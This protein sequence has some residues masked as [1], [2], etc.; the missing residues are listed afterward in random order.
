MVSSLRSGHRL[1][2]T[3]SSLRKYY[4]QFALLGLRC[5]ILLISAL[6]PSNL[7]LRTEIVTKLVTSDVK[8]K[9]LFKLR[10]KVFV[11]ELKLL[12]TLFKYLIFLGIST[13]VQQDKK[14]PL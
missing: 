1:L 5:N 7:N 2:V 8:M 9:D 3:V 10:G 13:Y 14:P 6:F 12:D 11:A 4:F